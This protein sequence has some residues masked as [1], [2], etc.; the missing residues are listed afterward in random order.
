MYPEKSNMILFEKKNTFLLKKIDVNCIYMI[1][2]KC[3]KVSD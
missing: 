1:T 3:L 2:P